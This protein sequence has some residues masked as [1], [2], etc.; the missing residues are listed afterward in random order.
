MKVSLFNWDQ[1]IEEETNKNTNSKWDK[2]LQSYS[3]TSQWNSTLLPKTTDNFFFLISTR[4]FNRLALKETKRIF[5][6]SIPFLMMIWLVYQLE[7]FHQ[8]TLLKIYSL[9]PR[10]T[11]WLIFNTLRKY[12]HKLSQISIASLQPINLKTFPSMNKKNIRIDSKVITLMRIDLILC[13]IGR[14]EDLNIKEVIKYELGW[15]NANSTNGISTNDGISRIFLKN[16]CGS[17]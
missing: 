1:A 7:Q 16:T 14:K 12:C 5:L 17:F 10:K 4:T 8:Q 13:L 15:W 11:K 6:L 9:Q 3:L 2:R